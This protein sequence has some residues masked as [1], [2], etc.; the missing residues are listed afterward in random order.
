MLQPN[1]QLSSN[2]L[3]VFK[4]YPWRWFLKPT[5]DILIV[6]DGSIALGSGGFALGTVIDTLESSEFYNWVRFRITGVTRNGAPS[7]NPAATSKE[8]R[9][10]GFRFDQAG[11]DLNTF[12]QV[13][14]FGINPPI[15]N[16]SG[17]DDDQIENASNTPLSNA[18][19]AILAEWMDTQSGGVFA[20]GDH[21]LL[22]ASMCHRIP[23]VRNMREWTLNQGVPSQTGFDRKDTNQ[24]TP[25]HS[26]NIPFD[27][28]GD[29]VPQPIEVL[30]R[31]I[32]SG[33]VFQKRFAP[34]P[35]LCGLAGVIDVL[36]D[37]PHE[38]EVHGRRYDGVG[39]QP[40]N[41]SGVVDF[42][43]YS[44]QEYPN[45]TGTY[46]RPE[47]EVIAIG[48]P[49][50]SD[51]PH[52]KGAKDTSPFGL[53]SVYDG[54][55]AG[56]G[57]VIV[58]S[59]WHHWFNVNLD[60]FPPASLKYRQ[61]R[62]YFKNVAVWLSRKQLRNMMLAAASWNVLVINFD[63]MRFT[64][65]NRVWFTGQEAKDV[66]GRYA[67]EC[68]IREWILDFILP[69]LQLDDLFRI[70]DPCLTCPPF[71]VF[72]VAILGGIFQGLLP[73]V[74]RLRSVEQIERQ[75]IDQN[76]IGEAL[77]AGVHRGLNELKQTL[78]T[79]LKRTRKLERRLAEVEADR[80]VRDYTPPLETTDLFVRL[81]GILLSHPV[82]AGIR[83]RQDGIA[84]R[85][86]VRI[87]G[88]LVD[89]EEGHRIPRDGFIEFETLGESSV[90]F[91]HLDEILI[92]STF[93][94]G[95]TVDLSL[96]LVTE[97][98]GEMIWQERLSGNPSTWRRRSEPK[99]TEII[100]QQSPVAV[101]LTIGEAKV[102]K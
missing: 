44:A 59:T 27:A 88:L 7:S 38:G 82:F 5:V 6:A 71:E 85:V 30:K 46:P 89:R 17:S 47:P 50:T 96:F 64:P 55:K 56:V 49:P 39:S 73:L 34:H 37:H 93:Q 43:G 100:R 2:V 74:D 94:E 29:D 10:A 54:E 63:P 83:T 12:D 81:D 41:L 87:N 18:E 66:L 51:I 62:N 86:E 95:E 22:G 40:I 77:L 8:F 9:Y 15:H 14:F 3:E 98:G 61:I 1:I 33:F 70:P 21:G 57:R 53:I 32:P 90:L 25:A 4:Y 42:G 11:F 78:S 99:V 28:Q 35:V 80:D 65:Q 67:S 31:Q 91:A 60:G 48:H 58:D 68:T 79:S 101:W 16:P 23:R 102:A 97:A 24:R 72:E 20:T 13:W 26:T 92:Q 84:L 69:E 52:A 19:L 36:P 76:E 75:L 45:G